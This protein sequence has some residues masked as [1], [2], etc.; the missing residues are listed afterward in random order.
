MG[1]AGMSTQSSVETLRPTASSF[2]GASKWELSLLNLTAPLNMLGISYTHVGAYFCINS[3]RA[4]LVGVAQLLDVFRLEAWRVS[5]SSEIE[6]W[7]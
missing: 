3:T 1:M 2:H 5:T 7:C 6:S 4:L